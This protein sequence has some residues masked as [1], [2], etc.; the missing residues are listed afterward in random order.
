[1]FAEDESQGNK[2]K[3]HHMGRTRTFAHIAGNWATY[4]Y[5]PGKSIVCISMCYPLELIHVAYVYLYAIWF[6]CTFERA[7]SHLLYVIN[8]NMYHYGARV[9]WKKCINLKAQSLQICVYPCGIV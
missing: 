3:D 8:S 7:H 4:L 9:G 6:A 2:D 1:M 5:I